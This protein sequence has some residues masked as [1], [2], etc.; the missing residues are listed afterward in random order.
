MV[1][2]AIIFGL[3]LFAMGQ[4][5]LFALVGPVIRDIG[6]AEWQAGVIISA[7]AL[8]FVVVSPFWGWLSDRWGRKAVIV[9]GLMGYG[10]T[11]LLFA[12]LLQ[13]GLS[14]LVA[15][16]TVFLA[17]VGARLLYAIASG[18]IQPASVALMAD[19]TTKDERSAGMALV[20]AAFGV[21]SVLGPAFASALVGFGILVPL[22][23]IALAAVC[24][25]I[26]VLVL[27]PSTGRS[28]GQG[29]VNQGAGRLQV[30]RILP[31]LGLMF[32][33]YVAV[34]ALQQTAA[35]FI[36]DFTSTDTVRAAQLSGYAFMALALGTLMAQGGLVQILKP[37]PRMM[38]LVGFPL[39][40]AGVAAYAVAPRFELLV[41]AF[42]IMGFGFGLVQPGITAAASL[43]TG[44]DAQGG[45]AGYVQ[46]SM[47]AGFVAG[48]LVGTVLYDLS[49][50]A[51]LTLA[52]ACLVLCF[53]AA[54]CLVPKKLKD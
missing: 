25:G 27:V 35:F 29:A 53:I 1:R 50:R 45:A 14:G 8:M 46:A 20:G 17:L 28:A 3:I 36:Q 22:T 49:P 23:A 19:M 33:T 47:A 21:G 6:L 2:G 10:I 26:F 12:G 30:A 11:T 32:G 7:S 5:V 37:P 51:P 43:A 24:T 16:T 31:H 42:A 44:A 54:L 48:P 9:C 38:L 15:A 41:A 18:G 34:S 39:A 13:A 52:L 40:A 4:T